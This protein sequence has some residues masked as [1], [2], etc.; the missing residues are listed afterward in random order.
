MLFLFKET[1]DTLTIRQAGMTVPGRTS[2]GA[3]SATYLCRYL[4]ADGIFLRVVEWNCPSDAEALRQA[5]R[6]SGDYTVLEITSGNR[7]IWCGLRED[8]IAAAAA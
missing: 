6:E 4:R 1:R 8:A 5:A 2:A 7:L 3:D